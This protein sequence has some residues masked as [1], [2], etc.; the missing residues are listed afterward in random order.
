MHGYNNTTGTH[1]VTV[2]DKLSTW[3]FKTLLF[4]KKTRKSYLKTQDLEN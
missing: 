1:S 4:Q 3:I 2:E